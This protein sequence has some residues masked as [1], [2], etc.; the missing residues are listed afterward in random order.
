MSNGAKKV[1]AGVMIPVRNFTGGT[2]Y[3]YPNFIP[4]N[5]WSDSFGDVGLT[6]DSQ[7]G[8]NPGATDADWL[9]VKNAQGSASST[10]Y[11]GIQSC[12]FDSNC[13]GAYS[14]E[15]PEGQSL[16]WQVYSK[17]DSSTQSP[18]GVG[19][20]AQ[21]SFNDSYDGA[22]G[23]TNRDDQQSLFSV[24][25][26]D[27]DY[28]RNDTDRYS[29]GDTGVGLD[30]YHYWSYQDPTNANDNSQSIALRHF[31]PVECVTTR[32]SCCWYIKSFRRIRPLL[33]C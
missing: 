10:A 25:I 4:S 15:V 22:S 21:I 3:F 7:L 23:S 18:V 20:W 13:T 19:I 11:M 12:R 14:N 6:Y 24:L 27:Y 29:A 33:V 8:D 31:S 16:F 26:S 32:E 28:R 9:W 5:A 1:M 2:E 17:T 30:G